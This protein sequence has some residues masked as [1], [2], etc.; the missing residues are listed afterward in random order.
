MR[1]KRPAGSS[2]RSQQIRPLAVRRRCGD[3]KNTGCK[4]LRRHRFQMDP[5]PGRIGF[6][7]HA[8]TGSPLAVHR[9]WESRGIAGAF[10]LRPGHAIQPCFGPRANGPAG[11]LGPGDHKLSAEGSPSRMARPSGRSPRQSTPWDK[12]PRKRW[13]TSGRQVLP[14]APLRPFRFRAFPSSLAA[15]PGR[16]KPPG[17]K[18]RWQKRFAFPP[19]RM[20]RGWRF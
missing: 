9:L 10:L 13:P 1:P 11:H 19:R 2:G 3:R 15:G 4:Y 6:N 20:K 7:E 8:E 5:R 14:F 12:P 18:V 16:F 17:G